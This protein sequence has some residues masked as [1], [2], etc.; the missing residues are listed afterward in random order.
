MCSIETVSKSKVHIVQLLCPSRHCIVAV[1][2]NSNGT[3]SEKAAAEDIIK[4][5]IK[6][7]GAN[8][9]CGICGATELRFEDRQSEF[10]TMEEA[11]PSLAIAQALNL[12]TMHRL[13]SLPK[14]N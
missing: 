10:G 13:A 14:N 4:V 6:E 2:Y 3:D 12:D 11:M 1:A 9:W 8:P 5:A 7:I